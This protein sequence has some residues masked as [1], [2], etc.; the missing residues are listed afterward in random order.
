MKSVFLL[1]FLSFSA[2][3]ADFIQQGLP[4][5]CQAMGGTC[6]SHARGAEI[7]FYSPAAL[8]RVEG[9][10]FKILETNTGVS[11]DTI[12]YSSQLSGGGTF[13][14]ADIDKI[15]G[16]TLMF[17]VT[18]R[19]AFVVPNFG[20]GLF[21]NNYTLMKFNDPSFPTFNMKFISDYGYVVG[22]SFSLYGPISMG[23]TLRH[24]KRWGGD[25]DINV[26]SLLGASQATLT[27]SL[28]RGVGHAVDL[29]LMIPLGGKLKP[30]LSL[31]WM[32]VGNTTFN[33][34]TG[35]VSPPTQE[36]NMILGLSLSQEIPFV[37]LTYAIEYKH[38][39]EGGEFF[40][41]IHLGTEASIGMF[42]LRAGLNH[43]YVSYGAGIDL[44]LFQIDAAIYANEL[45]TYG[46][47]SRSDAYSVSLTFEMD[48]DQSFKL[49]D[50]EGKRRRLKQRR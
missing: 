4:I 34:T 11:K 7:L 37:D 18:A 1:L 25:Q 44:W 39:R 41:K 49:R 30:T 42:D 26:S 28:S 46:G 31:A 40:K 15:Y 16:K 29:G 36:N 21:S 22:G 50:R 3:A 17:D 47:Q 12:D 6:M 10:N 24:I 14:Q 38:I 35:T 23:V 45:G 20:F 19:S 13:T 43:G 9:F 32:D 2:Q 5:R 8:S 33:A 48:F 27:N